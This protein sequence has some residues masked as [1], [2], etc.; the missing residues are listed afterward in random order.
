MTKLH[1]FL[2]VIGYEVHDK[3]FVEK[4]I[5][6]DLV[7]EISHGN[8]QC[9]LT[10]NFD[11]VTQEVFEITA[12]D[13]RNR[14]QYR[15]THEDF[16]NQKDNLTT[17]SGEKYY[18]LDMVEDML[19]KAEAIA[20]GTDYDTRVSMPL[21]LTDEDFLTYAKLLCIYIIIS[22]RLQSTQKN[23]LLL[24]IFMIMSIIDLL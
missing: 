11:L 13:Y 14:R 1:E 8:E 4:S 3:F 19:D 15:W 10:C 2:N 24:V 17:L 23:N 16:R 12:E 20:L 7:C 5:F 18:D 9:F 21:D 6:G 22:I